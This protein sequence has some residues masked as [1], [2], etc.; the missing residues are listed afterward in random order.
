LKP[1]DH[2]LEIGS[3]WGGFAVHAAKKYGCRITTIT[4]SKEQF[5][6]AQARFEEEKLNGQ[7]E[8]RLLDYRKMTGT[9]DKIAS[10]EMLEAVGH[11]YLS[12]FF[13]KC[14]DLLKRNG[15]LGLQVITCPDSRYDILRKNVDWIQKHIFPG[16]LL[17][18]IA[19]INQTINQ[20]GDAFLHHLEDMGLHYVKTL[21]AWRENFNRN[22]SQI[23]SMGFSETFVR[24][25]NYYLSYCE[26]AFAM[27]NITVTQ[28]IYTRPNN[29]QL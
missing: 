21:A 3:G 6:H 17:P 28:L 24:K 7:I 14:H 18:S 16:S 22:L 29:L 9:F 15:L 10:I 13:G 19:V 5:E 8:I 27:R 23:R 26:A 20:T 1:E 4:I 2:L 12:T 25:W 11:K